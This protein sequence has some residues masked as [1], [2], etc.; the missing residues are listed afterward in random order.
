MDVK[1]LSATIGHYSAG[2]TLGTY[3]RAMPEMMR[4]IA[5]TMR[6]DW[7]DDIKS[8]DMAAFLLVL[9]KALLY[10]QIEIDRG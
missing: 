6:R 10:S 7:K 5:N 4:E 1:T 8:K 9:I 2:F 3:T